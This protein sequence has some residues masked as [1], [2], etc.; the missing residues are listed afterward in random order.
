MSI[1]VLNKKN[2]SEKSKGTV[3]VNCHPQA[4]PRITPCL[5]TENLP[6]ALF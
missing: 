1:G 3:L 5:R 4:V 2:A 6:P